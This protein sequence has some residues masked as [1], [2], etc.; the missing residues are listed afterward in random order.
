MNS[1]QQQTVMITGAN[2]GIGLEYVKQYALDGW[3]VI[4]CCRHLARAEALQALTKQYSQVRVYELDVGDFDQIESLAEALS[5]QPIA[6]VINNAGVY[7][8][9]SFKN[10]D[11]DAWMR[12][13]KINT[14]SSLKLAEV[15]MPHMVKA[16]RAKFVA[17]TSKMGSIA[18]NTSGGEYSYRSTKTALNMVIKSLSWDVEKYGVAVAALH[19]GW[20]RTD[21]GG[22]NGLI[23][24]TTSV[25]GLRK[26]IAKL[27][28]HQ[29]GQFFAYDGQEIPW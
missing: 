9:S 27:D 25:S 17:M 14:M 13:F 24:V 4:A 18:D 7:P 29:S 1:T 10:T 16:G 3:H 26:V 19:P 11:Y 22:P 6:L 8:P 28:M 2:R 12:A 21:M 5:S 20:V 15:F 23:D